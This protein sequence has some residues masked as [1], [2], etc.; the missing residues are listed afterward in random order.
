[1]N[2]VSII[3][4]SSLNYPVFI[5]FLCTGILELSLIFSAIVSSF[6]FSIIK[7]LKGLFLALFVVIIFN[8]FRISITIFII[9]KFN[10]GIAN[11]MHGFLFRLFIIIIVIGTYYFWTKK[12]K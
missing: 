4:I 3:L 6:N 9:T 8:I 2:N 7:R 5:T 1:M 10:L 12:I 11:L